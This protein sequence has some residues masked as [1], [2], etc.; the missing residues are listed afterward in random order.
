MRAQVQAFA[1]SLLDHVR[2]SEELEIILNYEP[3]G[4]GWEPGEHQNLD[5]L[6]MA[7]R[8]KQ[9]MVSFFYE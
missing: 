7:I 3:T 6:K 1:T 5:R 8:Y 2:T 9:K 4:F